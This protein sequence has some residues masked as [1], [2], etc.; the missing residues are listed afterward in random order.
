MSVSDFSDEEL[1]RM[2][3]DQA[4]GQR[5][6]A[7]RYLIKQEEKSR[8]LEISLRGLGA[9]DHEYQ[10]LVDDSLVAL[11]VAIEKGRF[12]SGSNIWGY[13]YGTAR[14]LLWS[15]RRSKKKQLTEPVEM[16]PDNPEE[17]I[18]SHIIQKERIDQL[19]AVFRQLSERCQSLL[20][21]ALF[22][23]LNNEAIA[24]KLGFKSKSVVGVKKNKCMNRLARLLR[25]SRSQF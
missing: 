19:M 10:E 6:V 4:G 9:T 5:E 8:R 18:E 20:R 15:S 1:F 13:L 16:I 11:I 24:E 3:R 25:D 22:E 14:N 12:L 17:S 2:I 7:I 21:L 23:E